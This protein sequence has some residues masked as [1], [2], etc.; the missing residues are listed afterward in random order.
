[1]TR[2]IQELNTIDS[3][4]IFWTT[5]RIER[6]L[7]FPLFSLECTAIILHIRLTMFLSNCHKID[8]RIL[9]S[10]KKQKCFNFRAVRYA[11]LCLLEARH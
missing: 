5:N 10:F 7:D 3:K 2:K 9:F 4:Q 8:L 1:M 6:E 11:K